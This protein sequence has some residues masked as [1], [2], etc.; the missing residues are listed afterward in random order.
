LPAEAQPAWEFRE[1]RWAGAEQEAPEGCAIKGNITGNG[2][3]YHMP[4]STWYGKVKVE[5]AKGERWFCTEDEAQTAGWRAAQ[6]Q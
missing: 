5:P 1:T 3:I 4:W 2:Q 6:S